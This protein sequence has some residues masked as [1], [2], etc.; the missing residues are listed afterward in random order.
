MAVRR[1]D[2]VGIIVEDMDAAVGFFT[3][4]GLER[5]GGAEVEGAWVDRIT[6]VKGVRSE[7]VMLKTPDGHNQVELAKF[8]APGAVTGAADAPSNALGIRHVTFL[9]TD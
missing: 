8:H 2:H 9:V 5:A 7:I 1:M 6:A 4:L 3:E